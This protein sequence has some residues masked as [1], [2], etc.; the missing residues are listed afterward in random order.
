MFS[1]EKLFN[2]STTLNRNQVT[3]IRM[4]QNVMMGVARCAGAGRLS[5]E[6]SGAAGDRGRPGAGTGDVRTQTLLE[7]IKY[8]L[9]SERV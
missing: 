1:H 7:I 2:L 8:S 4:S 5:S 3:L 9:Y 6:V